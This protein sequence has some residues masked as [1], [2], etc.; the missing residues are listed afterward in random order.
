[1]NRAVFGVFEENL[2]AGTITL[3]AD[4]ALAMEMMVAFEKCFN[5]LIHPPTDADER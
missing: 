4:C 1:M 5:P 2:A 3:S